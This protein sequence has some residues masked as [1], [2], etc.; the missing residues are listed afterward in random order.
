MLIG[1]FFNF[2]ES[3]TCCFPLLPVF[4]LNCAYLLQIL[5]LCLVH[6]HETD[7]CLIITSHQERLRRISLNWLVGR[8]LCCLS[9]LQTLQRSSWSRTLINFRDVKFS[10]KLK[11]SLVKLV[12]FTYLQH[13][14]ISRSFWRR[15][16]FRCG[17][18][19]VTVCL[20]ET[21]FHIIYPCQWLRRGY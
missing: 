15:V 8:Y 5:T 3:H 18:F 19:T 14:Y 4:M 16:G 2:W 11:I 9:Q 21:R 1:V 10:L 12:P 17:I 7:I 20:T 6:R 13:L